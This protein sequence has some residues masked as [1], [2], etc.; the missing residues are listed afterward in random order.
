LSGTFLERSTETEYFEVMLSPTASCLVENGT[1]TCK[2]CYNEA[3]APKCAGCGKGLVGKYRIL[4]NLGE[5][6][7]ECFKCSMCSSVLGDA[8]FYMLNGAPTCEN[9]VNNL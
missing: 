2:T 9:C 1:I 6:H 7:N 5:F 3:L 4:D 8:E